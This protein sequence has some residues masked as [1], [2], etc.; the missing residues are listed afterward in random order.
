MEKDGRMEGHRFQKC[1]FLELYST[2]LQ[3]CSFWSESITHCI[4]ICFTLSK[5]GIFDVYTVEGS[6]SP[7]SKNSD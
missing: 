2:P 7:E 3:P 1:F 6:G 4:R 5:N